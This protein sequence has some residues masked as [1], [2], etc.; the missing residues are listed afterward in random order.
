MAR[1]A[2]L[3]QR[4]S[5]KCGYKWKVI[6]KSLRRNDYRW[7][8]RAFADPQYIQHNHDRTMSLSAH[9]VHRRLTD[10]VKATIKATSRRVGIRARD[11]RGIVQEKHHGTHFTRQDIYNA[12]ALLRREKLGRLSPTA[13]LIKQF[14]ARGVP[15]VARWSVAEPDRLLGLV[16]TFPY[17]LRMWKRYPEI[18]SFDNTYNTNRF[19]LPLFQVTGQTC[20]KSVYNAAFGLIDNERREGFQFLAEAVRELNDRH[21]IPLPNVVVTDYDQQMKAAL[22]SQYPDSQ[23]QIYI[24]HVNAN[25]LLN[26]KRKW[27]SEDGGLESDEDGD[28]NAKLSSRDME[29]VL[30]AER[31]EGAPGQNNVDTPVP[32]NS[33][34]VLELWKF[35]AFTETKQEHKKAWAR[36]CDVFNDQQAILMYLYKTYLPIRAQ[37]AQCFIKKYRNF[38]VRVTSGTEASN[39]NVKSYLLNGMSHLYSLVE[40]IEAL[41]SD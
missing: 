1:G 34:G 40:A 20:L 19:K 30:V 4:R 13:A 2:G 32:H 21:T 38:G 29:A 28:P 10:S 15:Y 8:L 39:N 18:M 41:L 17:C 7:T 16:W 27:K 31:Q 33:R 23:Q 37:W 9:T 24:Q 12:R 3:R 25:V 11:V 35:V 5:R 22:E 36:L 26:A 14:D 6:A